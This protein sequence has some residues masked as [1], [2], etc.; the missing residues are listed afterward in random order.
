MV[1]WVDIDKAH[2]SYTEQVKVRQATS[3]ASMH[4][5]LGVR[6]Y[7][8]ATMRIHAGENPIV[9]RRKDGNSTKQVSKI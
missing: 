7:C 3:L 9:T 1:A 2:Q 6:I 5:V 4:D 8:A